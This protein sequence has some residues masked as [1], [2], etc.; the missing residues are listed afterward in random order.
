M[1]NEQT[2]F[3]CVDLF[4][5]C[6]G[7]SEGFVQAGFVVGAYLERDRW[8]CETLRT[9]VMFYELKKHTPKSAHWYSRYFRGEV[10]REDICQRFGAI[11]D[12]IA[13]RV[14]ERE[15]GRDR[16]CEIISTIRDSL[17]SQG[18][19]KV[20]VLLGGPPCQAYSLVGRSR[21]PLRMEHDERHFLYQHYLRVLADLEP[22]FFVMENVPGLLSARARGQEIFRQMLHDFTTVEPAYEV[23]PSYEELIGDPHGYVLDSAC[24][25]VPQ[26]RRRV[27]LIGYRKS[28]VRHSRSVRT[29]FTRLLEQQGRARAKGVLTVSDAIGDLP[30]LRPGEGSDRWFGSYQRNDDLTGFQRQMRRDSPGVANHRARTHMETDLERYRFFIEFHKNGN[31]AATLEDLRRLRPDLMPDHRNTDGFLDRFKVQWYDRPASTIMSHIA[32]DG[33]YYIHPDISQCRSFTVR[34]AARCQ[35]FPDNFFF[36]GP[37]T[38]QFRQVGNAV[39][40]RM[41]AVVARVLFDELRGIYR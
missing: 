33:H 8:A 16:H 10:D 1:R 11:S 32:K 35:S 6:G 21:D 30:S 26:R 15:F 29:A 27:L 4:A 28:L 23:A 24:F 34:E 20:H 38:E 9:R 12:A 3:V 25:R 18:C 19:P 36:E 5:G 14:I 7:L 2:P 39:P 40:P 13:G 37:R 31:R 41:A 22:D 17:K